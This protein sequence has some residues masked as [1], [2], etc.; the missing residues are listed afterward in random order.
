MSPAPRLKG[1]V[2][3]M[4]GNE[5]IQTP[6]GEEDFVCSQELGGCGATNKAP[7]VTLEE[8]RTGM[9][10]AVKAARE[11]FVSLGDLLR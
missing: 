3:R 7:L 4:C 11:A 1:Y 8:K 6:W 10:S 2:C 9:S 5:S